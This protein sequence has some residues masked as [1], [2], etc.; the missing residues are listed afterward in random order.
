MEQI[1]MARKSKGFGELLN[2]QREEKLHREGL[3][4]LQEKVQHG[5]LGDKFVGMVTDPKGEVKMSEVLETFVEPYLDSAQN[6]RQRE[7]LF[8]I[9]MVAWNLALMPQS[10]RPSLIDKMVEAGIKSNDL[11][12]Q[13]GTREIINEMIIRKQK[14]FASNKRCIIDF[15]L[16]DV[17][18]QFHLSVA[19]TV[20]NPLVA[21]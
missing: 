15:Q 3:A 13:Q 21:D 19:S 8:G 20:L 1:F 9:A 18:K 16:Q 12:A 14:F 10:D 11:L 2:Q 17:G 7:K 4:K 5:A 6:H